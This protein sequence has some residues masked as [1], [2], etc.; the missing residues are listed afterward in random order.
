MVHICWFRQDLRIKDH[1][2]LC[3]AAEAGTVLPIYILDDE[4]AGAH[5]LGGA[6]RWWLHHSLE[7]LNHSLDGTLRV[8][9]GKADEVIFDLCKQFDIQGVF[10]NRCYEP[11]RMERDTHIKNHLRSLGVPTRS[12]NG[13]LLWEPWEVLKAD[14]T[15]YKVF[16]PYFQRGCLAKED[17]VRGVLPSPTSLTLAEGSFNHLAVADLQ[18]LSSKSWE[19]SLGEHWVV[20]EA[21]AHQALDVFC[22]DGGIDDYRKGRDFPARK[23]VSRL[24]PHLHWGEISV[25]QVWHKISQMENDENL[26][27]FKSELGWREFSHCT[28]YHFPN[29]PTQ[30]LR[31]KFDRFPWKR[32]P[33]LLECWQKGQ[34]GYPIVD[35]GMRELWQTGYMHNR[36]RMVVASFLVKNLL[37]DWRDGA[38][39]FWDCLVD[40]DLA[41]N[42]ASWQWVAGCGSDAA[43]FFRIFSPITQGEKFDSQGAY[44]RHYVPELMDVPNRYLFRPWEARDEVLAEA[45]VSLGSDYPRPIVEIGASRDLALEAFRSLSPD[46][47]EE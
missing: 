24:S 47:K 30:N 26:E 8:Y 21:A 13:S 2:A 9:R 3:A 39:W 14:E 41:N 34:T 11:W 40:A 19:Q 36:V 16:T 35:A 6:S 4:N 33:A 32:D 17:R 46:K 23:N 15:P 31:E 18:L 45:G 12:F 28:L 20:G 42:S 1:P 10:W 43:P 27:H 44:T 29:L 5:C 37:L 22:D 38:A 7:S 25:H